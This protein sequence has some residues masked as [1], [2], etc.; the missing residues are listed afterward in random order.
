VRE[1]RTPRARGV[2]GERAGDAEGRDAGISLG[3]DDLA[4][5]D[6]SLAPEKSAGQR[7]G[8]RMTAM[9]DR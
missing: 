6:T 4:R 8:E 3:A 7:Y 1:L 9:V 2:G 5:V